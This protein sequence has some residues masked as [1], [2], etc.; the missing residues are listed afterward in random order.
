M[1]ARR[2]RCDEIEAEV[3]K[4]FGSSE[5]DEW[6]KIPNDRLEGRTP[7]EAAAREVDGLEAKAHRV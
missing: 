5:L 2:G 7:L 1:S 3:T 4:L 6:L